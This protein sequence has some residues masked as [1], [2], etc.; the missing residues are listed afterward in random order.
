LVRA[1]RC[2]TL[3]AVRE[4]LRRAGA[5]DLACLVAVASVLI[6]RVGVPS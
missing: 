3:D 4:T 2:K 1:E 5:V 6:G